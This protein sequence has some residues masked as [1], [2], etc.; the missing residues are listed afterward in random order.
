[1]AGRLTLAGPA[2][3]MLGV[4]SAAPFPAGTHALR[5]GPA[6]P[7]PGRC[8]ERGPARAVPS[9]PPWRARS[10]TAACPAPV[11]VPGVI[12]GVCPCPHTG[13]QTH[14]HTHCHG[15]ECLFY[16]CSFN[17]KKRKLS[18]KAL[19]RADELARAASIFSLS[20]AVPARPAPS[21]GCSRLQPPFLLSCASSH[22]AFPGFAFCLQGSC[23]PSGLV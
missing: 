14:T 21:Q 20:E 1:M 9:A 15:A 2:G 23:S 10:G 11:G 8:G 22:P 18:S 3:A 12:R 16:T 4:G 17:C 13:L 5:A 6:P 7:A 19:P